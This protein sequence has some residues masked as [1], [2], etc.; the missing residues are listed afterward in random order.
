[1]TVSDHIPQRLAD[2]GFTGY[3]T[4]ISGKRIEYVVPPLCEVPTGPFLMGSDPVRD[5]VA[6]EESWAQDELPQHSVTL[7]AYQI[8]RYPV[9]VTEYACFVRA[10]RAEPPEGHW[11]PISWKQQ[12]DRL[13]HPVVNVSWHDVV[14]YAKWLVEC[15]DHPWRLP[16]EAEWEKAARGTDARIY[17]WGNQFD[18]AC[19]NTYDS[20]INTTTPIDAYPSGASPYGVLDMAGNVSEWTNTLVK[21]YPYKEADGRED[22][23]ATNSRV[24]RGGSWAY[25]ASQARV[26]SR[27]SDYPDLFNNNNG[28]RLVL[29]ATPISS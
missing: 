22:M 27:N 10:G 3:S 29:R 23:N 1:M 15:T 17:P 2:L 16:T 26:A 9:T 8:T 7:P 5:V 20:G 25:G 21:T 4:Q 28:F 12:L 13:D 18:Q 24:I 19:C 14:A 11:R 6:A